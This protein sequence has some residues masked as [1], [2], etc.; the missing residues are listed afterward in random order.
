MRALTLNWLNS[1]AVPAGK[2]KQGR[3]EGETRNLAPTG[4]CYRDGN[5]F[6]GFGTAQKAR[7]ACRPAGSD[8]CA[9]PVQ[10]SFE[11]ST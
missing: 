2:K 7:P 9:R 5:P 10:P 1:M 11:Q 3:R 4:Q 6:L 8:P